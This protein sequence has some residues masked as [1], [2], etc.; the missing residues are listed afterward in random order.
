MIQ[1]A[2][3]TITTH[4]CLIVCNA[5]ITLL[6][7]TLKS[8]SVCLGVWVFCMSVT[9]RDRE[10]RMGSG[11]E[12]IRVFV[13]NILKYIHNTPFPLIFFYFYNHPQSQ[14]LISGHPWAACQS[15]FITV[16][17]ILPTGTMIRKLIVLPSPQRA[18]YR[19]Y[20]MKHSAEI[21]NCFFSVN[22][23]ISCTVPGIKHIFQGYVPIFQFRAA[24]AVTKWSSFRWE[25]QTRTLDFHK[26][27]HQKTGSSDYHQCFLYR[28]ILI[29]LWILQWLPSLDFQ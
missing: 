17:F 7:V 29:L 9:N 10:R 19:R 12:T 25:N 14:T 27:R 6:I 16:W 18:D 20:N 28:E 15:C 8:V 2:A 4:Q 3:V 21:G 24:G 5:E 23:S 26:F 1:I 13:I 22:K 11:K